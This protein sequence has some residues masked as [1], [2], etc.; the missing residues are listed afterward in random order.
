[1]FRLRDLKNGLYQIHKKD[2]PAFE[3]TPMSIFQEAVK[4]GVKQ[5]DLVLA[6][7]SLKEKNHDYADFTDSGRLKL[8]SVN[9]K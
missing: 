6:A 4:L 3:G 8:T 2:G 9:R 7:H 5:E 1:M